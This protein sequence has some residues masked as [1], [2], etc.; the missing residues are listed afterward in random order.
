[1]QPLEET[2]AEMKHLHNAQNVHSH[3]KVY[4]RGYVKIVSLHDSL[5]HMHGMSP[6]F[7]HVQKTVD[8]LSHGTH[9]FHRD[10]LVG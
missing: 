6:S 2:I 4:V 8:M 10:A 1:M 5:H 3:C 9:M 7:H